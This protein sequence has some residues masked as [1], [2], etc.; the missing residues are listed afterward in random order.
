MKS[1]ATLDEGYVPTNP[2]QL[3]SGFLRRLIHPDAPVKSKNVAVAILTLK[4]GDEVFPH[5]H[6]E[7][8]E[9]Y[10]I[11]SGEGVGVHVENGKEEEIKYVKDLL[12]HIPIGVVHNIKVVGSEP[13]RLL[14]M[15]APPLPIDDAHRA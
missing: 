14:N 4:P 2:V 5:F 9:I 3:K 10:F 7:R 15:L 6:K 11:L 12:I 8:E 1:T 13:L